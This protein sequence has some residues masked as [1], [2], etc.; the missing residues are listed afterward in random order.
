MLAQVVWVAG[1]DK[2]KFP[3]L[4]LFAGIDIVFPGG[5]IVWIHN[6][7]FQDFEIFSTWLPG[8]GEK[9]LVVEVETFN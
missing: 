4:L 8:F 5:G 9:C 3:G 1:E 7:S 2:E 6:K